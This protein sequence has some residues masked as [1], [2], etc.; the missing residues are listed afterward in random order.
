MLELYCITIGALTV[1]ETST[2]DPSGPMVNFAPLGSNFTNVNPSLNDGMVTGHDVQVLNVLDMPMSHVPNALEQYAV[3]DSGLLEGIPG[4]M[5]DWRE[6]ISSTAL[7]L[8]LIDMKPNF[9]QHNGKPSSH[10]LTHKIIIQW[11]LS[12][13]SP[14]T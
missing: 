11:V 9:H 2:Q 10:G 8:A 7:N 13:H 12:H 5:F 4:S 6:S 3:A 14:T 1:Q